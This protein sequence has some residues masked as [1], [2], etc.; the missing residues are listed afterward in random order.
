MYI[1]KCFNK[2]EEFYKIGKTYSSIKN[3]FNGKIKMPYKYESIAIVEGDARYISELEIKY[4]NKYKV[5]KYE[6]RIK[7]PGKHECFNINMFEND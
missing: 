1:I 7:F 4:K 5:Y 3:R 6:P 2:D